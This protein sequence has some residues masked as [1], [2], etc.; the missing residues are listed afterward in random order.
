MKPSTLSFKLSAKVKKSSELSK[1]LPHLRSKG[2]RIVFTNGCFDILHVG[3]VDYLSKAR[4]LGDVLVV[5][6]NSDSSVRKIKGK[7]RPINNERDRAKVLSSLS[8][9]DYISIFS[10]STPERLI[11]EL[12]PDILAKGGDWKVKNIVGGEFVRSCGGKVKKIPFVKGYSTTSLIKKIEK[13]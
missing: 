12:K 1:L 6:L 13:I 5:G 11:R 2:K 10:E 3:H 4:S 8:C 7:T 9:V